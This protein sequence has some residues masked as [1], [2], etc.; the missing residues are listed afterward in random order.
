[1]RPVLLRG[2]PL[3]SPLVAAAGLLL[4]LLVCPPP[5]AKPRVLGPW[6]LPCEERAS[7]PPNPLGRDPLREL[8]PGNAAAGPVWELM[9]RKLAARHCWESGAVQVTP[10]G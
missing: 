4:P 1:M 10:E 5:L 6:A 2:E 3:L 9:D 8:P 7:K